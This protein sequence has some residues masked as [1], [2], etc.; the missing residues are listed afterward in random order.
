[1]NNRIIASNRVVVCVAALVVLPACLS[2][3]TNLARD[4][5]VTIQTESPRKISLSVSGIYQQGEYVEISG[6]VRRH[7]L[8]PSGL[9]SGHVDVEIT[10]PDGTVRATTGVPTSPRFIKKGLKHTARFS[11]QVEAQVE[12]GTV[13][14]LTFHRGKHDARYEPRQT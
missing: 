4:S 10:D 5:G 8:S 6:R 7:P 14:R 12:Q 3:M 1:V 2:G 9:Y 11:T 13:I